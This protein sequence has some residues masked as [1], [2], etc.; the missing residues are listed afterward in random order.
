MKTIK[1]TN[2]DLLVEYCTTNNILAG[3]MWVDHN[4]K[5]NGRRTLLWFSINENA[6]LDTYMITQ[7]C[8]NNIDYQ[9]NYGWHNYHTGSFELVL[10]F[11]QFTKPEVYEIGDT[12]EILLNIKECGKYYL[13]DD[14]KKEMIGK[15]YKIEHVIDNNAGVHYVILDCYFPHY[16]VKKIETPV[17]EMT[18]EQIEAKLGHKIKI[19][20]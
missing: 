15:E 3:Q 10:P 14:E 18:Q 2:A 11:D 7:G 20:K 13:F 6:D 16:C 12:V 5:G 8:I 17:V 19:I 1:F 9:D 4:P